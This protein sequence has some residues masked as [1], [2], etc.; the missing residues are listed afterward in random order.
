MQD[1]LATLQMRTPTQEQPPLPERMLWAPKRKNPRGTRRSAG[2]VPFGATSEIQPYPKCRKRL[3]FKRDTE[4]DTK[5][6][7]SLSV[8]EMP[9]RFTDEGEDVTKQ[10]EFGEGT[11]HQ[12]PNSKVTT[13]KQLSELSLLRCPKLSRSPERPT[14]RERFHRR[15]LSLS[16]FR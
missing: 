14:K 11:I 5:P 8:R 13:D 16:N 15:R 10:S 3:V 12:T 7:E 4:T 1:C 9:R 2:K 6:D